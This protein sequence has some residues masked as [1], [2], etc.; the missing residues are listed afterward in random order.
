MSTVSSIYVKNG[1]FLLWFL[2]SPSQGW[3]HSPPFRPSVAWPAE[4]RD[5]CKI[6]FLP[7]MEVNKE[8]D[9]QDDIKI[10]RGGQYRLLEQHQHLGYHLQCGNW[11]SQPEK[12]SFPSTVPLFLSLCNTVF[13]H[14]ECS[15]PGALNASSVVHGN[16][17]K[18][19]LTLLP[20]VHGGQ[21]ASCDH[22]QPTQVM[23]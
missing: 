17:T 15:A 5:K 10:A 9:K 13:P 14:L 11:R 22:L 21:L 8:S 3:P 20:V 2:N 1:V 23:V 12:E 16:R 4:A 6:E 18:R 7:A 19:V